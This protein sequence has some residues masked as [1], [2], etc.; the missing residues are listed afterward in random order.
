VSTLRRR[1]RGRDTV[2]GIPS[3][4]IGEMKLHEAK[5]SE[6]PRERLKRLREELAAKAAAAKAA[7]AVQG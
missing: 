3:R 2:Q 7:Q 6:D 5:A 1:K 4:F